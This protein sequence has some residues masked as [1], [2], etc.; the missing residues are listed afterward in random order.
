MLDDKKR[1]KI[2]ALVANGSSRRMAARY[3][4]CAPSTI[5]RTAMRDAEFA[6]QLATAEQ[7][8]DIDA[9]RSLRVAAR[10]PRF[11][12]AAA[13]LLERRN[14]DE[15]A[16]R[17]PRAFTINEVTYVVAQLVE[18]LH[19]DASEENY[20]RMIEKLDQ[21]IESCHEEVAAL[22]GEPQIPCTDTPNH[23]EEW[24][25]ADKQREARE[26]ENPEDSL[27]MRTVLRTSRAIS[28]ISP[29]PLGEGQGVRA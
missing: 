5:T 1:A 9:L 2:V 23:E 13:W 4:G 17:P 22:R 15:F 11:W 7:N 16:S 29:L 6:A 18:I 10:K 26:R 21:M 28:T 12:R 25:E 8:A 19:K 3:V 14:P 24:A 20:Q 27:S